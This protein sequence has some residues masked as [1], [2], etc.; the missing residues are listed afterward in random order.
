MLMD[1]EIAAVIGSR[2]N[3]FGSGVP[4]GGGGGGVTAITVTFASNPVTTG[5]TDQASAF[6]QNNVNIT[7][8]VIWSSSAAGQATVSGTGLV[9]AVDAGMPSIIATLG[10]VSGSSV[11]TIAPVVPAAI[12]MYDATNLSMLFNVT[13]AANVGTFAPSAYR[14]YQDGALA[15]TATFGGGAG[16]ALQL[17][18]VTVTG[19]AVRT[20]HTYTVTTVRNGVESLTAASTTAY[21][22]QYGFAG[23]GLGT[24]DSRSDDFHTYDSI[25][26][27]SV[28]LASD[29]RY[30]GSNSIQTSRITLDTTN[31]WWDRT[32]RIYRQSIQ[33]AT[34]ELSMGLTE[35]FTSNISDCWARCVDQETP[36]FSP[37]GER[38]ILSLSTTD[39]SVTLLTSNTLYALKTSGG[40]IG[41]NQ[42]T[43]AT[44]DGE[45]TDGSAT[46]CWLRLT[47][48]TNGIR[49]RVWLGVFGSAAADMQL[50]HDHNYTNVVNI[51]TVQCTSLNVNTS[52][53]NGNPNISR[54]FLW[55]YAD[56][57][58]TP[59]TFQGASSTV[60]T[61]VRPS[62]SPPNMG[63]RVIDP[64]GYANDAAFRADMQSANCTMYDPVGN[65][66]FA[67]TG[68]STARFYGLDVDL[69]RLDG[70][71][72][73]PS[74][75]KTLVQAMPN[76][77]SLAGELNEAFLLGAQ[78]TGTWAE[79]EVL[80]D[81]TTFTLVGNGA[82]ATGAAAYKITP[83]MGF[84]NYN[85]RTDL[86][87]SNGSG[88]A[89]VD[90]TGGYTIGWIPTDPGGSGA[91]VASFNG[92]GI[93]NGVSG[94]PNEQG[95]AVGTAFTD[96]IWRKYIRYSGIITGTGYTDRLWVYKWNGSAYVLESSARQDYTYAGTPPLQGG[97]SWAGKN[98]NR[99]R[100]TQ[101]VRLWRGRT[102]YCTYREYNKTA[103]PFGVPSADIADL[104]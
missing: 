60:V 28:P 97:V 90:A 103:N 38:G 51:T 66:A 76:N 36:I 4:S 87:L 91:P 69:I 44:T 104:G 54:L 57:A 67:P 6:D 96:N 25:T 85:G 41:F 59:S 65:A 34:G 47:P 61:Y 3:R 11:L 68:A 39:C 27:G 71:T 5:A 49:V 43:I 62:Y 81:H 22:P 16:G 100:G 23:F 99:T 92:S 58:N 88:T 33:S 70:T 94:F 31:L 80:Y 48:I 26:G 75:G 19:A 46:E 40:N 21:Q 42:T 1:T 12:V 77:A 98:F 20:Q 101:N 93:I 73:T 14:I 10:A 56:Q 55:E 18:T 72:L 24:G 78:D 9:T 37:S 17:V 63:I 50:V 84:T 29:S 35:T 45:F 13:N 102:R 95:P 89:G 74:G 53:D 79:E 83:D 32:N 30:T 7:A 86:E 52:Y 64:N 2:R 15:G 82:G 8:S